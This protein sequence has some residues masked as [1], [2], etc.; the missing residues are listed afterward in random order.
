MWS[1]T[2]S[3]D[4]PPIARNTWLLVFHGPDA[5]AAETFARADPYVRHGIVRRW[6][7][8]DWTVVAGCALA[9]RSSPG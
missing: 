5:S 4:V 2:T 9:P 6:R 1:T 8:R 7:V 3:I